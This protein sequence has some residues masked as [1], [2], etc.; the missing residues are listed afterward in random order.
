MTRVFGED[1]LISRTDFQTASGNTWTA[2]VDETTAWGTGGIKAFWT[3]ETVAMTQSRP[4]LRSATVRL[5]K[6]ACLVPITEEML[7]D[8]PAMDRYLRSKMPMAI[9]W[10]TSL[11]IVR[12][13][14]VGQPL[15]FMNSPA[16]V[17]VL[18]ESGQA[19]NTLVAA[20]VA[21]MYARMPV[22]SR[23]S[24]IWLVH[25]DVEPLLYT[26]SISNQPI[27]LPPGGFS[28][29]PFGLLMGRPVMPH[30]AC[31]ALS[32]LGDIIFFD[33][34]QYLTVGKAGGVRVETSMHLW[35]DQDIQ[36]FKATLRLAGQ[37]WWASAAANRA[38]GT[39]LGPYVTLEAR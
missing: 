30:Q 4:S 38:G 1:S 34:M 27:Y 6:L 31:S 20:N 26:M 21:K 22:R 9:D 29:S 17:T 25:P 15:G 10:E 33:P 12:G 2:P 14:G 32:A 24:A 3:A 16:L 19:A 7:D 37:P 5:E 13:T 8:A 39:S 18:K 23:S 28:Q 11:A 35:F 36:A